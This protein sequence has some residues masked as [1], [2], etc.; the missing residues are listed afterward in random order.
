[1]YESVAETSKKKNQTRTVHAENMK[2]HF[3]D[4]EK[5]IAKEMFDHVLA[6]RRFP[7]KN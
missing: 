3:P 6:I 7:T 5:I 2:Q 1:M 4:L